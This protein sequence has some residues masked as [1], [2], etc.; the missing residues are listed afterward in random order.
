[1]SHCASGTL[2]AGSAVLDLVKPLA[3]RLDELAFAAAAGMVADA[4][5][6]LVADAGAG[7][8]A[9]PVMCNAPAEAAVKSGM[10]PDC[11]KCAC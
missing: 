3:G 1:M 8:V 10:P 7:L 11:S 2:T 6:G 5:A 9:V 4:E